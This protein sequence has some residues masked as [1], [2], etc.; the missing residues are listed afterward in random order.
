M[1]WRPFQSRNHSSLPLVT[2]STSERACPRLRNCSSAGVHVGCSR[3]FTGTKLVS[4]HTCQVPRGWKPTCGLTGQMRILKGRQW[5]MEAFQNPQPNEPTLPAKPAS[6]LCPALSG[7]CHPLLSQAPSLSSPPTAL[8]YRAWD[9][10]QIEFS[11][12]CLHVKSMCAVF[13]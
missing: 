6:V 13:F 2:T 9:S 7:F 5:Q 3:L 11:L 4:A 10:P 12:S 1:S 8:S